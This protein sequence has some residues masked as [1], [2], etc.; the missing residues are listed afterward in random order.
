MPCPQAYAKKVKEK[1]GIIFFST[2]GD[3]RPIGHLSYMIA[4]M[5]NY[6]CRVWWCKALV[7][8]DVEDEL[9][10]HLSS[11]YSSCDLVSASY[12]WLCPSIAMV[13]WLTP[14]SSFMFRNHFGAREMPNIGFQTP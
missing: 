9:G 12:F 1:N 6:P 8:T 11:K 14:P 4:N 3:N 7:V 13:L 10:V 5:G 2:P